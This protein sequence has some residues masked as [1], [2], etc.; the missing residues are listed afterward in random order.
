MEES[1]ITPRLRAF[2][3]VGLYAGSLNPSK[4]ANL[5]VGFDHYNTSKINQYEFMYIGSL[6]PFIY[7]YVHVSCAIAIYF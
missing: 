5:R 1:N 7:Y 2:A 4:L 3:R 6:P